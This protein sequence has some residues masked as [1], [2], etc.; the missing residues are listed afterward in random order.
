MKINSIRYIYENKQPEL[1]R[2]IVKYGLPPAKNIK[3]LW[4]KTNYLVAKFKDEFLK[5]LAE[6]HPD[7]ELIIWSESLKNT[8]TNATETSNI[9]SKT[10]NVKSE[11]FSGACGCSGF[12]GE[13]SS[14][15][16]GNS[17]CGCNC[18]SKNQNF[19]NANGNLTDKVKDNLPLIVIGSLLVVGG[20]LYFG[21]TSS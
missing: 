9:V 11:V 1:R 21:K 2:L 14:N 19:S 16:N 8:N 10:E 13:D 6:I 3:D 4:T 20:L 12:D 18:G 7:R 15:C 17:N 5:D